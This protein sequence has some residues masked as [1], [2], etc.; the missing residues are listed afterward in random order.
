MATASTTRGASARPVRRDA[1]NRPFRQ[2]RRPLCG[3]VQETR[4]SSRFRAQAGPPFNGRFPAPDRNADSQEPSGAEF[5]APSE[6]GGPGRLDD[7]VD[8]GGRAR[9]PG[10]SAGNTALRSAAAPSRRVRRSQFY[11][12]ARPLANRG[13]RAAAGRRIHSHV[14]GLRRG[15]ATTRSRRVHAHVSGAAIDRGAYAATRPRG[16]TRDVY[17]DVQRPFAAPQAGTAAVGRASSSCGCALAGAGPANLPGCSRQAPR[18]HRANPHRGGF[19][20]RNRSRPSRLPN[21]TQTSSRACSIPPRYAMRFRTRLHRRRVPATSRECSKPQRRIPIHNHSGRLPRCKAPATSRRFSRP[22]PCLKCR[23]GNSSPRP[24]Q[25]IKARAS[26]RACSTR[27]PRLRTLP[28]RE[29]PRGRMR[30]QTLVPCF[31]L[32][33]PGR[34]RSRIA[35]EANLRACS[36]RLWS[37]SRCSR[38]APPMRSAKSPPCRRRKPL[39]KASLRA[40]SAAMRGAARLRRLRHRAVRR[41]QTAPRVCSTLLQP[42]LTRLPGLRISATPHLRQAAAILRP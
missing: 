17:K 26:S 12:R 42:T 15:A 29:R 37:Q 22:R 7:D 19:P 31:L 8:P 20:N 4:G 6:D 10:A 35:A 18:L 33:L 24:L 5:P 23:P 21:R 2:S 9:A 30:R 40:S 28:R 25:P 39:R 13:R 11:V 27:A 32:P 14:S 34:Q 36:T 38:T 41:P 16:G 3:I 1:A